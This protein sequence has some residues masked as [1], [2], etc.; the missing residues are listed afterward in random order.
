M[1]WHNLGKIAL[2]RRA[3]SILAYGSIIL[4][5]EQNMVEIKITM[6][7]FGDRTLEP[8]DIATG[9]IINTGERVPASDLRFNYTY[10]LLQPGNHEVESRNL[11]GTVKGHKSADGILKLLYLALKNHFEPES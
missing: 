5:V 10:H 9:T 4:S 11:K 8:Y 6:V 7:P 3:S 1:G 2:K